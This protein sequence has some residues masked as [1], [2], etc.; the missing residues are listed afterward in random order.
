MPQASLSVAG[1]TPS[2][3]DERR[4]LDAIR[5]DTTDAEQ[6]GVSRGYYYRKAD[7]EL[8]HSYSLLCCCESGPRCDFVRRLL[9]SPGWIALSGVVACAAG[10]A[11][12]AS[13]DKEGPDYPPPWLSWVSLAGILWLRVL[14]SVSLVLVLCNMVVVVTDIKSMRGAS[15][16]GP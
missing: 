8:A 10:T 13:L 14:G 6:I 9:S 5:L 3:Q 1:A 2:I 15:V 16:L 7:N 11:V 12:G 4:G